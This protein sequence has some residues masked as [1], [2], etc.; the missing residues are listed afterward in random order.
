[1]APVRV[2]QVL[3]DTDDVDDARFALDLHGRLSARGL[4]VRTM[5]LGPGRVG[6][7]ESLVPT[8][9]P[10]RRS[11]AAHTQLRREQRWADVV[12]LRG[13]GAASV[14]GLAGIG[15]APP[16]VVALGEEARRWATRPV[17]SRVR[18][19]VDRGVAAV[20]VTDEA[21]AA[22]VTGPLGLHPG[23]LVSIPYG[24]DVRPRVTTP[25]ARHA[26][27]ELLGLPPEDPVARFVGSAGSD[28]GAAIAARAC[29]RSGVPL[30]GSDDGD[31][32][33]VAAAADIAVLPTRR[34]CGPPR[35]LLLAA[36]DGAALV[37]PDSGGLA[38]LVNG[39]TGRPVDRDEEAV[40]AAL[41]ALAADPAR[42]SAHGA[43][44]SERVR[45]DFDL[46]AVGDRWAD[47]LTR[48]AAASAGS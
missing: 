22:G 21:A 16:T 10:S 36:R 8:M 41:R 18:R 33:V 48:A 17:P 6:G 14:A 38:L 7:L 20:V 44:A 23:D 24:V 45:Q 31:P 39:S 47:L 43:A 35:G 26:A 28:D 15:G 4:E 25:T 5:A 37:A 11:L 40:T 1:M 3:G 27:R 34:T 13:G 12:V 42:L 2:L 29:Q 30:I 9:S 46:E 32:E 19:L